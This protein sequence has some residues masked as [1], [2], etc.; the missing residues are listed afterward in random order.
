MVQVSRGK[1]IRAK[2]VQLLYDRGQVH[3]CEDAGTEAGMTHRA[4]EHQMCKWKE[5]MPSPGAL[6]AAV[7]A[8][9]RCFDLAKMVK[10]VKRAAAIAATRLVGTVSRSGSGA[11]G[12]TVSRPSSKSSGTRRSGGGG[13]WGSAG[14]K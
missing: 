1:L 7:I 10:E 3:H 6:D 4:L 12:G 11:A 5:G 13:L 9:S 14:R 8:L 2:P